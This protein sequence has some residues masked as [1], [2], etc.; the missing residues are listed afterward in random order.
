MKIHHDI[1]GVEYW[2]DP[3]YRCWFVCTVDSDGNLGPSQDAYTRKEIRQMGI[4]LRRN[5][6]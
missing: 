4:N 1:V 2:Y 6:V 3:H 5:K